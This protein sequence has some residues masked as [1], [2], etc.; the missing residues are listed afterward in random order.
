MS[1]LVSE[2][3][4]VMSI[5]F[6]PVWSNQLLQVRLVWKPKLVHKPR[7]FTLSFSP[8]PG[9]DPGF[10]EGSFGKMS[11]YIILLLLLFNKSFFHNKKYGQIFAFVSL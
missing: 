9:A 4:H 8:L 10:S 11:A 5:Q 2:H 1:D 7:G 3:S 6:D